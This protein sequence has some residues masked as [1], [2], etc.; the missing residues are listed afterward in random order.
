MT[1]EIGIDRAIAEIGQRIDA[2]A[3]HGTKSMRIRV[4]ASRTA[5]GYSVDA[6]CELTHADPDMGYEAMGEQMQEVVLHRLESLMAKLN[7]EYPRVDAD[8]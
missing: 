3:T 8:A 1:S 2:L 5:K 7:A 4:N 6:T